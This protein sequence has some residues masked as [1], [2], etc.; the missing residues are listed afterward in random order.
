MSETEVVLSIEKVKIYLI[1]SPGASTMVVKAE[2]PNSDHW[3]CDSNAVI[4]FYYYQT[5]L[6][7]I[8]CK[9]IK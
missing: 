6:K 5:E 2:S 9:T 4:L 8:K 1:L 3:D 7:V